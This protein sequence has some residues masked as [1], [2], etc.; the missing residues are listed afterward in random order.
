M[1]SS[2][3]LIEKFYSTTEAFNLNAFHQS[4]TNTLANH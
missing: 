4:T 1:I 3:N 2:A